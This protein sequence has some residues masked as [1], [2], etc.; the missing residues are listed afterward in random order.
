M[1]ARGR[2]IY[3]YLQSLA[4]GHETKV[5][6]LLVVVDRKRVRKAE[7]P[8]HFTCKLVGVGGL[9]LQAVSIM[10]GFK[11]GKYSLPTIMC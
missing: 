8:S 6:V 11:A 10:H 3:S 1:Q 2:V 9:T 7:D 5:K 4:I